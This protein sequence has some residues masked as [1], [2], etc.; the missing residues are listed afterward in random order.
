MNINI[1][2]I[3]ISNF[4]FSESTNKWQ[5]SPNSSWNREIILKALAPLCYY[6]RYGLVLIFL[7]L[8]IPW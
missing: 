5:A 2:P 3:V 1:I 4:N 7:D 8:Q 6:I